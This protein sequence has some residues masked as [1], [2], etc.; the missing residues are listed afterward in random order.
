VNDL[1]ELAA[2]TKSD[3]AWLAGNHVVLKARQGGISET[4]GAILT[5]P[6]RFIGVDPR[7]GPKQAREAY[8]RA[9]D[10]FSHFRQATTK[11]PTDDVGHYL[12]KAAVVYAVALLEGF[13]SEA[14]KEAT[15]EGL[16]WSDLRKMI[17]VIIK[18]RPRIPAADHQDQNYGPAVANSEKW[19]HGALFLCELRNVIVHE[20]GYVNRDF[21][22]GAGARGTDISP[23]WDETIWPSKEEFEQDFSEKDE[24]GERR[25]VCLDYTKVILPYLQQALDFVDKAAEKLQEFGGRIT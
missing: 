15:G 5:Y 11:P 2:R 22:R 20:Q 24:K 6:E 17:E 1:K 12:N 19:A 16:A 3:L 25:Q 14:Y 18:K 13:L 23:I 21:L 4:A 7:I 10:A 8:Q 9:V